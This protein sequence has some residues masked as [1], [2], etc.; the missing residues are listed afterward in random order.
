MIT[1]FGDQI[2][3]H[4]IFQQSQAYK[5]TRPL[6]FMLMLVQ[7]MLSVKEIPHSMVAAIRKSGYR[8]EFG[9]CAVKEYVF[10]RQTKEKSIFPFLV[11]EFLEQKTL[12]GKI[13]IFRGVPEIVR[14]IYNAKF[15]SDVNHSVMRAAASTTWHYINKTFKTLVRYVFTPRKAILLQ[16]KMTLANQQ[17]KEV[18]NWL[19]G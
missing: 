18:V 2:N 16:N 9:L 15:Y 4:Y 13:A 1:C 7:E 8:D 3:W 12:W 17:T 19:R 10:S 11:A 5:I 6:F 14:N